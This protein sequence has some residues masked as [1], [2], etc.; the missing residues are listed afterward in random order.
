M[1]Q[2]ESMTYSLGAL[3]TAVRQS[4]FAMRALL[5]QRWA[6]AALEERYAT[7]WSG[8]RALFR[9]ELGL[10]LGDRRTARV[11]VSRVQALDMALERR[12]MGLGQTQTETMKGGR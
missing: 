1:N 8:V 10:E 11:H 2:Q 7:D 9:A 4:T 6:A 5:P 12:E 3:T